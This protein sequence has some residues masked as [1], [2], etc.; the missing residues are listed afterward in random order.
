M[1]LITIVINMFF[2]KNILL[3]IMGIILDSCAFYSMNQ[4]EMLIATFQAIA[5]TLFLYMGLYGNSEH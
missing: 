5:G 4:D 2:K 3:I 1:L